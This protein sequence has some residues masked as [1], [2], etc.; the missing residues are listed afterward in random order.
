M[1]I[2][3]VGQKGVFQPIKCDWNALGMWLYT[4]K[5][6]FFWL[7]KFQFCIEMRLFIIILA[8]INFIR[9]IDMMNI[10]ISRRI[11]IQVL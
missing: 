4:A 3:K 1:K 10:F 8:Q 5:D 7:R 9:Q 2:V 6:V 11:N